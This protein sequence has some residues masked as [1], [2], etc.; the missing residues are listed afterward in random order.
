MNLHITPDIHSDLSAP[1]GDDESFA[2]KIFTSSWTGD[3]D[4]YMDRLSESNVFFASR[5]AEGIGMSFL[6][7]MSIGLCVVAPN[8]PTMNEYLQD[9]VNGLLYDPD[10]PAPLDF[11]RAGELGAA[12]HASVELGRKKWQDS[13]PT[14][15]AFL[16]DRLPSYRPHAHPLLSLKGQAI[17]RARHA[18]RFF[19]RIAG[20]A[21]TK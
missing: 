9:G 17:A 20:K 14:I 6:E 8:A 2:G 12:A 5:A 15:R 21:G 19:K 18:Y 13:L 10:H 3:H 1:I 16:D 7:A 11:G 4:Q